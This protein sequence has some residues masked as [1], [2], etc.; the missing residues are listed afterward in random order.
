MTH[1]DTVIAVLTSPAVVP[2]TPTRF[3]WG[4][5]SLLST[6]F[7][8]AGLGV[9]FQW[10]FNSVTIPGATSGN[11]DAG[12]SGAYSC[13]ITVPGGCA[14]TTSPVIV[15]ESPLPDPVITFNGTLIKTHNYYVTY[16]WYKNLVV[17]PG[18]TSYSTVSTGPG[19]YKVK[20]TDT[21]SCQ[22]FSASYIV[23]S[24]APTGIS[25]APG[26]EVN[27]FPNPAQ[28]TVYINGAKDMVAVLRSID[29]RIL[30]SEPD[31]TS[32]DISGYADGIYILT[33]YDHNTG[34]VVKTEKIV[35]Y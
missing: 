23:N 16:Q 33:L 21:N 2:L 12:A 3:C 29:G 18:A 22:T 34:L 19:S 14:V 35:K 15:V 6:N 10:F 30:L 32:I 27:I 31:V 4:S 20:V 7:S 26:D 25:V 17:I 24:S 8:T 28:N 11:Y 1:A 9:N 13:R 5:T